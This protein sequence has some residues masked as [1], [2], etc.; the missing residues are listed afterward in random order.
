MRCVC[1]RMRFQPFSKERKIESVPVVMNKI[2]KTRGKQQKRGE[3]FSLFI[4][5]GIHPLDQVPP[6]GLPIDAADQVDLVFRGVKA[7]RFNIQEQ[8]I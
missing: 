7:G 5:G 1:K 3:N 2:F 8:K 6:V 4:A